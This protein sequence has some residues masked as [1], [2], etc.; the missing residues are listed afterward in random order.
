LEEVSFHP[1]KG[2]YNN[3]IVIDVASLYPTMAV[4]H[5]ISLDTIN[6]ECCR[7][8]SESRISS[9]ITK[10]CK[11]AKQYWICERREGAFTKRLRAFKE[12]RLMQKKLG[13]NVK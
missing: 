10:D 13:N 2:L 8:I 5:N 3:L 4:L 12:E 11:I 6:C 1:K 7:N 9:D